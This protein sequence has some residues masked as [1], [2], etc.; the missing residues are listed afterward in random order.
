M[1]VSGGG[2]ALGYKLARVGSIPRSIFF[3]AF[4][5]TCLDEIFLFSMHK[6][7]LPEEAECTQASHFHLTV[8][9]VGVQ[10]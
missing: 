6:Q 2:H 4:L 5:V 8:C 1:T 3:L 7:S 10:L 9:W